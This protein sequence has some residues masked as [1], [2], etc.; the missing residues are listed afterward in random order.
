MKKLIL[1]GVLLGSF[2]SL[3][4]VYSAPITEY[5]QPYLVVGDNQFILRAI[6][7][8]STCPS[9]QWD[10][11]PPEIM[12]VRVNEGKI[13]ARNKSELIDADFPILTCELV[14]PKG[15]KEGKINQQVFKLP[16]SE[17][18]KIVVV[19]DTGCRLKAAEKFYQ[20]CNDQVKWP[21]AKV[22]AQA[23][24]KNPDLVIHVGDLHY[25]E[26]P[27]PESLGGCKDSPWGYGYD[28]WKADFFDPAKPL[29]E[30]AA[31]VYVRGNH[32]VC[33]RAGQG[34]H[35]FIDTN[36]WDEKRSCNNPANDG[37]GDYSEPFS[38]SLGKA[39]QFI[40]FD[41]SKNGAKQITEK[42]ESFL[43][44]LNQFKKIEQLAVNKRFNIF[45]SHH[46]L[47]ILL[48]AKKKDSESE[49]QLYPTGF[50]NLLASLNGEE[51]LKSPINLTIHGHN[52]I[53]EAITY[54]MNRPA[55]IVSGNSGSSLEELNIPEIA[56][57]EVQKKL[58]KI[59]EFASYQNFGFGT[60]ERQDDNG[61][62]WLFTE[63]DINGKSLLKCNVSGR[64]VICK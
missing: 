45:G 4:F 35:R 7:N 3:N 25:R 61:E 40:V 55:E 44:Y 18:K 43:I 62:Q 54:E 34:W 48:P 30:K 6:S 58:L 14:W 21:L 31:W 47:N 2:F 41:S 16:P 37:H 57:S 5:L 12:K 52:H 20:D 32:E 63:F 42:D 1:F 49:Y 10:S 13:P 22:M 36:S 17:I 8:S 33:S 53:F 24:M 38:V 15:V 51:L 28:A 26:S 29:L 11:Q 60:L 56:L 64:T 59:K 23:A 46:P 9:V 27:C 50:T 19:G 39:A